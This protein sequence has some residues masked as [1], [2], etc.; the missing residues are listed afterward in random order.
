VLEAPKTDST[1][2]PGAS[3]L[4][5]SLK[6][7]AL[8]LGAGALALGVVSYVRQR[9]AGKDFDGSCGVDASTGLAMAEMGSGKTNQQC[10]DFQSTSSSA[11][12]LEVI[13]LSVAGTLAAA[14]V[15]LWLTEP[16]SRSEPSRTAYA[17]AP[18]LLTSGTSA[19]LVCALRF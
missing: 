6:W 2:A 16:S 19:S 10:A 14:G 11:F 3:P 1:A 13:G 5:H 4:R 18:A 17:C 15:V 8:G 12:R 7:V 9:G